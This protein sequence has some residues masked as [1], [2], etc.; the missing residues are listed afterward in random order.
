MKSPCILSLV[1][2]LLS[3]PLMALEGLKLEL[4]APDEPVVIEESKLE[5]IAM[6]DAADEAL[7]KDMV[8][9]KLDPADRARLLE[10][11]RAAQKA[12]LGI[13]LT[14]RITNTSEEAITI[15]HGGD[16]TINEL[17]LEGPGAHKLP[18][19]GMMTMEFRMGKPLTIEPGASKEFTIEELRYGKREL[20]RWV[21][22]KPGEYEVQLT[23]KTKAGGKQVELVSKV[24]K[25]TVKAK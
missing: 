2:I 18:F 11:S 12:E 22:T 6:A 7:Q 4:M 24:A 9:K 1:S 15:I 25:F 8:D 16:A 3:L 17:E 23:H 19:T 14:Y 21:V 20:S 10:M 5:A 13:E